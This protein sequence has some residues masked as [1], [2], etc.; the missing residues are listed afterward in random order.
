MSTYN[1]K[2]SGA[3]IDA[4]LEKVDSG[5]V[6]GF[7]IK[8]ITFTDRPSMWAWLQ[9]NHDKILKAVLSASILPVPS[10][11]MQAS[12]QYDMS[13]LSSVVFSMLYPYGITA[14]T[15]GYRAAYIRIDGTKVEALLNPK[16]MDFTKADS[17]GEFSFS[18]DD[19]E[20]TTLPDAYWSQMSVSVTLYYI[21]S[22]D[23][24]EL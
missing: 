9:N 20:L 24:T 22:D 16:D 14:N 4:L 17:T 11:F 1:S 2:F 3:E 6:G 13:T 15:I 23:V 18:F 19:D 7:T 12:S 21:W 10:S 8:K 5:Q